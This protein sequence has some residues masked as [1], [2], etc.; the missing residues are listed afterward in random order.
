MAASESIQIRIGRGES[1][2]LTIPHQSVSSQHC[3][4]SFVNGQWMLDD[5]K[6]TNGTFVNGERVSRKNLNNGDRVLLGLVA[7]RFENG[8]LNLEATHPEVS[9]PPQPSVSNA[10]KRKNLGVI[11][12][13]AFALIAVVAII[14]IAL[15][16]DGSPENIV[17]EPTLVGKEVNL[18]SQPSMLSE[19]IDTARESV[20]GVECGESSGT[21]WVLSTGGDTLIVT[22]H[23]VVADCVR[24]SPQ[25]IF[26]NA[27]VSA[28][29]VGSDEYTDLAVLKVNRSL[30]SLATASPPPIG[31][32][33]MVIGNPI[34]LDRSINYGTLTNNAEGFLITDA[35]INPGNS[36]GPVFNS[37]GEVIGVASAKLV[38]EGIDRIGLVIP[39]S[40]L[41]LQVLQC[42]SGQWIQP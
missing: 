22:N 30:T 12:L 11:G 5:L 18:F 4:I 26:D 21:G 7:Y 25:I 29:I 3:V 8:E 28:N 19:I 36:G 31:S 15:S 41:C 38:S 17:A 20:L 27:V 39:L 33:L 34:G 37:R 10:S 40:D 24:T 16:R 2:D 14:Y 35:A 23:H 9:T 13:S 32:W 1:N 42:E 6:S